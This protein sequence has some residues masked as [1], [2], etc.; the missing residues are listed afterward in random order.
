MTTSRRLKTVLRVAA[1][2]EQV[3]RGAAGTAR[4]GQ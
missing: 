2:Q 4:A 3:A 1:L